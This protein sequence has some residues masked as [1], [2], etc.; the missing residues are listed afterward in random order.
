M[1]INRRQLD[2]ALQLGM[3]L[4][5]IRALFDVEDA[6]I[7]VFCQSEYGQNLDTYRSQLLA[8][9]ELNA[10]IDAANFAKGEAVAGDEQVHR[11]NAKHLF[12]PLGPDPESLLAVGGYQIPVTFVRTIETRD[13]YCHKTRQLLYY[14]II[15]RTGNDTAPLANL[16]IP[17]QTADSR[18]KAQQELNQAR[19][20]THISRQRR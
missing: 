8:R 2:S 6:D 1:A 5:A 10:R 12:Q 15:N 13:E 16:V 4:A 18:L 17:F 11:A 20:R 9:Y 19:V 3:G 14:L 7:E